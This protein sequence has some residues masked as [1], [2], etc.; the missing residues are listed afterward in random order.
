MG[1][2]QFKPVRNGTRVVFQARVSFVHLTEA[3][4]GKDGKQDPRY[5]V[6]AIV[7][8]GDRDTVEAIREAV[9]AAYDAGVTKMWDGTRPDMTLSNF[10]NPVMEGDVWRKD[11]PAFADS[12]FLNVGNKQAVPT[13]DRLKRPIDPKEVYSGC[14]ALLSVNFFPYKTG[15][16]GISGGLNAVLKLYDGERLGGAGDNTKDF[17]SVDGLDEIDDLEDM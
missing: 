1:Q 5:S 8:K 11:D 16:K 10:G 4:R 6:C 12:I 17:D 9:M 15:K 3:W 2:K 7:P 14:H 13:L